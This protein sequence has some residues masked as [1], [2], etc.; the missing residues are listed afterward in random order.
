MV[1]DLLFDWC[2]EFVLF[3]VFFCVLGSIIVLMLSFLVFFKCIF[4]LI[5]GC[6]LVLFLWYLIGMYFFFYYSKVSD[7]GDEKNKDDRKEKR[8]VEES[9]KL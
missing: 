1:L 2:S 7:N 4:V 8:D 6:G 3:L 5:G 9:E